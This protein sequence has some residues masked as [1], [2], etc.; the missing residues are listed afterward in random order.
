MPEKAGKNY[1]GP[2]TNKVHHAIKNS[3]YIA[4]E[5]SQQK[6][7]TKL[8]ED[9]NQ[10]TVLYSDFK[11]RIYWEVFWCHNKMYQAELTKRLT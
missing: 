7:S 8:F 2:T 1:E 11:R 5:L 3:I 9:I 6:S 4:L 10:H